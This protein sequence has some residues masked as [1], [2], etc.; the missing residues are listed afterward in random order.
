MDVKV[1]ENSLLDGLDILE[2]KYYLADAGFPSCDQ[3][4]VTN[5]FSVELCLFLFLL[6]TIFKTLTHW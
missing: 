6:G 4:I 5:S 1:Y 2:G 3:L